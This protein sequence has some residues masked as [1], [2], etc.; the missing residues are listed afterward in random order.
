MITSDWRTRLRLTA[1][2][3][4]T[5]AALAGPAQA[6]LVQ[7]DWDPNFGA[8]FPALGWR[9]TTT[10][11]VP[12]ACLALS[13]TVVNDGVSCPLMTM[14]GALVEFYDIGSPVPTVETLDFGGAVIV[15][16]IFVTGGF[17]TAFALDSTGL[18]L[19]TSS[20]GVT[21]PGGEQAYFGLEIDFSDGITEAVLNW[22]EDI[23]NP[24]GGR[25]DPDFPAIV[26]IRQFD[27]PP[28]PAPVPATL[29][30]AL[31]GLVLLGSTRRRR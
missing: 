20:L 30:L 26:R 9:G 21:V 17:V 15:D 18:V 7:G 5:A 14:V 12:L 16:R 4:A 22:Y 3:V 2:A 6:A 1:G 28:T 19:S 24:A 10:I 27:G 25:S 29:A 23:G 13:G 11:D 31:A 8:P